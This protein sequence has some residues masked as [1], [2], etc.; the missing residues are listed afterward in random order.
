[1]NLNIST[2]W[3][4]GFKDKYIRLAKGHSFKKAQNERVMKAN[5]SDK[6]GIVLSIYDY[7]DIIKDIGIDE[8]EKG[9][10]QINKVKLNTK[11][12]KKEIIERTVD[13]V[14]RAYITVIMEELADNNKISIMNEHINL[15]LYSK[16]AILKKTGKPYKKLKIAT[17]NSDSLVQRF[18]FNYFC[19]PDKKVRP[20]FFKWGK[21]ADFYMTRNVY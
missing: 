16:D 6:N 20:H 5:Y 3:K 2:F 15:K 19:S 17:E 4:N 1:M 12:S 14:I 11:K 8:F 10:Y 7:H 9:M 18:K 21:E 13:F